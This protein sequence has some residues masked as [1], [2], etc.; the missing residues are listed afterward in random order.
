MK[1]PPKTPKTIIPISKI[2]IT[3]RQRV[4]NYARKK[5]IKTLNCGNVLKV[6]EELP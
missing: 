5:L 2:H 1:V 6:P 4:I 3:A